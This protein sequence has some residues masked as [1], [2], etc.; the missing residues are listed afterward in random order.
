M[1]AWI[2]II[3][4]FDPAAVAAANDWSSQSRLALLRAVY[5]AWAS[6]AGPS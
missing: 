5:S 3:T 2:T 6:S 1:S 4:A